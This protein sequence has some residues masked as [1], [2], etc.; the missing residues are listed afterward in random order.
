MAYRTM[1]GSEKDST[2]PLPD[3]KLM[4]VDAPDVHE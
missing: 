3:D 4:I 2:P 1:G